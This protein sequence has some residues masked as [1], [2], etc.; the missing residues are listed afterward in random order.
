MLFSDYKIKVHGTKAD[1]MKVDL[2]YKIERN[3]SVFIS[4][5]LVKFF[6][7][8]APSVVSMIN[9]VLV[10]SVIGLNLL[11]GVYNPF[12]LIIIQLVI[13]RVAIIGDKV[14][15][16]MARYYEYFTQK[17][18]YF[19]Q[20][21]HFCYPFTLIF[22]IGSY[23]SIILDNTAVLIISG[24]VAVLMTVYK[25]LGKIRHHIK[26]KIKLESHDDLIQDYRNATYVFKRQVI[27]FR[28]VNYFLFYIY[29][30]VW[31]LYLVLVLGSVYDPAIFGVIY[32]GY[33]IVLGFVLL[34]KILVTYPAVSLYSKEEFLAKD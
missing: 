8:L 34:K 32:T 14:D 29:D 18:L 24:I 3:I 12:V 5:F 7:K 16:E 1:R 2:V 31:V 28:L 6:P 33:S 13:L 17:G 19:D 26:Y 30:W 21:F 10:L 20:V 22:S 23:F 4:Y 11:H 25:M 27:F 9:V 15:G